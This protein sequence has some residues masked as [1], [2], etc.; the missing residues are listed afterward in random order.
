MQLVV[1]ILAI[2][3]LWS[4]AKNFITHGFDLHLK[5]IARLDE[6]ENC[7]EKWTVVWRNRFRCESLT[8]SK[9]LLVK[10]S[11]RIYFFFQNERS[12]HHKRQIVWKWVFF[13]SRT[14]NC[15]KIFQFWDFLFQLRP[16]TFRWS[17]SFFF[18]KSS[19]V[20]AIFNC[21]FFIFLIIF[22]GL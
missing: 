8:G 22:F 11:N 21:F 9:E 13:I 17:I 19:C 15:D 3:D 12:F 16:V 20:V 4:F 5:M 18:E 1:I 14:Q 10:N 7:W 6:L 2:A